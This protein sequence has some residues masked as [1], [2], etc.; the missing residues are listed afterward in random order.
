MSRDIK[1]ALF[2][3]LVFLTFIVNFDNFFNAAAGFVLTGVIPGTQLVLPSILTFV[4]SVLAL[5]T[6]IVW[7]FRKYIPKHLKLKIK[8]VRGHH[9][10][11]KV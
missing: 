9:I 7:A 10:Q 6:A 5:S 1:I 11:I 4:F 3:G 2:I 8:T